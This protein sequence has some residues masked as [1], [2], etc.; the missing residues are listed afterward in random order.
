M[1]NPESPRGGDRRNL[2]DILKEI[3]KK[4]LGEKN[5]H[6]LHEAKEAQKKKKENESVHNRKEQIE[7]KKREDAE[8][9][10]LILDERRSTQPRVDEED[11]ET[12]KAKIHVNTIG[13]AKNELNQ[14]IL[15][16]V[17]NNEIGYE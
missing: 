9:K 4:I 8:R 12:V 1:A 6:E 2:M 10:K 11:Y 16:S 17:I 3:L 7:K 5:D 14:A 13:E 15:N